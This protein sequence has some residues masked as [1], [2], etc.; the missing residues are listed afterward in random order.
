[1]VQVCVCKAK[2]RVQEDANGVSK[3]ISPVVAIFGD[4]EL[5]N[6]ENIE[7]RS[8]RKRHEEDGVDDVEVG[9]DA[10]RAF[11]PNVLYKGI[12]AKYASIICQTGTV[13]KLALL[14]ATAIT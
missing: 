14:N 5:E 11:A 10:R 3:S 9:I 6:D 4:G 7:K 13:G 1:L 12:G 2:C 8:Q